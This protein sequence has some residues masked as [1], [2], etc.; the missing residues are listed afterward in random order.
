[1]LVGSSTHVVSSPAS[2]WEAIAAFAILFY[3]LRIAGRSTEEEDT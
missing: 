1:V 3:W 2:V